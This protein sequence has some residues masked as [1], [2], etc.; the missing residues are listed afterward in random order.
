MKD[1]DE[2][3]ILFPVYSTQDNI[4]TNVD[5]EN[6]N[7]IQSQANDDNEN[8]FLNERITTNDVSESADM[9]MVSDTESEKSVN[10]LDV[11]NAEPPLVNNHDVT[12]EDNGGHVSIVSEDAES[13]DSIPLNQLGLHASLPQ[14]QMGMLDYSNND[15]DFI[16][17]SNVDSA[18][19][20]QTQYNMHPHC[21]H[22]SNTTVCCY[23]KHVVEF[24]NPENDICIGEV[25]NASGSC[26]FTNFDHIPD[27]EYWYN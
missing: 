16:F 25:Q 12:F 24:V 11:S 26:V 27:S 21:G 23:C 13:V 9:F 8:D 6:V 1:N 18:Y 14:N 5:I 7:E 2:I 20:S 19:N 3:E 10:L 4:G 22:T 15:Q 17:S